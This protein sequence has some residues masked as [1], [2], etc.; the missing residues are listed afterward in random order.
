LFILLVVL[1]YNYFYLTRSLTS[2]KSKLFRICNP[3]Y[4]L[5]LNLNDFFYILH[6]SFK[7][8]SIIRNISQYILPTYTDILFALQYFTITLYN[9]RITPLF[10]LYLSFINIYVFCFFIAFNY[11]YNKPP[12]PSTRFNLSSILS[13]LVFRLT[14]SLFILFI[15]LSMFEFTLSSSNSFENKSFSFLT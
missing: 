9:A 2:L 15:F 6:K 3:R 13:S 7:C 8:R 14:I 4:I 11:V 5:A 10:N 12:R 1:L